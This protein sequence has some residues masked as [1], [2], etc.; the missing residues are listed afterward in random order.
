V[1]NVVDKAG[2]Q[3]WDRVWQGEPLPPAV[4]PHDMSLRNHIERRFH[5]IFSRAFA[6]SETAGQMLLEVGAA[7]SRWLPYFA[8]EFGFD[9]TGLDYSAVGCEQGAT[10]MRDAGI[11]GRMVLGDLFAPPAELLHAFDVVVSFGLIEHFEDTASCVASL[12]NFLRPGGLMITSVPNMIG[13]VGWL[14]K[15][16]CRSI[17]DVHVPLDRENL[18]AAHERSGL[19]VRSCDYFL[20]AD[21]SVV[22]LSCWKGRRVYVPLLKLANLV[23]LGLWILDERQLSL[24]PNR[25]NSRYIFCTAVLP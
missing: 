24:K 3:Y 4:D 18:R 11:N 5:Q 17:Y 25:W 1:D 8:K 10:I 22:N 23:S 13:S 15:R 19:T 21:L 12:A 16:L 2:R 6:G 9:V 14:Q 7:R 20:G